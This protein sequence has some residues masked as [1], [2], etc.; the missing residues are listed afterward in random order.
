MTDG[1]VKTTPVKTDFPPP[2]GF[3]PSSVETGVKT[4]YRRHRHNLNSSFFPQALPEER[5]GK[6]AVAP[7]RETRVRVETWGRGKGGIEGEAEVCLYG[8]GLIRSRVTE[9]HQGVG[10]LPA[11]YGIIII[12]IIII[13]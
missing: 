1:R 2:P 11:G 12:V 10:A 5:A 7:G 4:S 6:Q 9:A 3:A 8:T 13:I